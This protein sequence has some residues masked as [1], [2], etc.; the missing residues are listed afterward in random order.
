[1]EILITI[2]LVLLNGF[3]VAAEFAIVKVRISQIELKAQSGHKSA[4]LSKK[5]I[6]NLNGYLA[7]TQLG[8]TLASLGLGWIG[9]PIVSQ[10]ILQLMNVVGLEI[11]PELAHDIALPVAFAVITILHIVF[12]ELAPKS[13]AIQSSER[14]TL[15]IAY[16][17]QLFYIVFKPFI[18]I[19]NGIA[20]SLL[21]VIGIH[22]SLGAEVH[23]SA[24][25]KYLIKQ[26]KEEG[27]IEQ[28][29]Y[30]IINNAFEFSEQIVKHVMVPRTMVVAINVNTFSSDVIEKVI[31]E[32]YSRIPCYEGSLDHV[33]GFV[34]LKDILLKLK[35]NEII[36]IHTLIRPVVIVPETKTI[37]SL[38][39][40]FQL[41]HHQL[42]IIVDEHG[43]TKGIVTM[44]DIL[45]ELVG[46]IQDE[47]DSETPVIEKI[48]EKTYKVIASSSIRDINEKLPHPI[49]KYEN[50][51][52][53]AGIL[54]S[55]IGRIPN[56]N[57]KII[58]DGYEFV[59]IKKIR[60][61][62][63]LVQLRD[64]Q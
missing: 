53:L 58:Y 32:G 47:Y 36:N 48:S 27:I 52:T 54:I 22:P 44:E 41:K 25:L 56:T 19:L 64:L 28:G 59:I 43:G 29:D 30:N 55:K 16:P 6:N 37:G 23:S 5:I 9:E 62:L 13:I 17:L 7:A 10:I 14:T 39:K 4:N 8:I 34:H 21:T 60:H 38:L 40:E 49:S 2:A 42:A 24:E 18:W 35:K 61:T 31:E 12:G 1:M 15:F 45:E 46:E 11:R 26:G 20:N 51:E 50:Y 57:E 33:M 63:I 3:F